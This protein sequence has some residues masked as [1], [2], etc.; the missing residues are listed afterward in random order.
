[1]QEGVQPLT[2]PMDSWVPSPSVVSWVGERLWVSA[3]HSMGSCSWRG[4]ERQRVLESW[5]HP[6]SPGSSAMPP[7]LSYPLCILFNKLW[8]RNLLFYL[9][10]GNIVAGLRFQNRVRQRGEIPLLQNSAF[11]TACPLHDFHPHGW[12]GL[13]TTAM[14]EEPPKLNLHDQ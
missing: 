8:E 14:G 2:C 10:S 6:M 13:Q 9:W 7:V 5:S 4:T 3:V 12:Q 11:I 1:M